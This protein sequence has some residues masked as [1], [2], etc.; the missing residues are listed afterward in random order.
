MSPDLYDLVTKFPVNCRVIDWVE[1][2]FDVMSSLASPPHS[3]QAV[4]SN[5]LFGKKYGISKKIG[6]HVFGTLLLIAAAVSIA[7]QQRAG[8]DSPPAY[9][10]FEIENCPLEGSGAV[11]HNGLLGI[12]PG[13]TCIKGIHHA[14]GTNLEHFD[15]TACTLECSN[16]KLRADDA[17]DLDKFRHGCYEDFVGRV[18]WRSAGGLDPLQQAALRQLYDQLIALMN[19]R[20]TKQYEQLGGNDKRGE[21]KKSITEFVLAQMTPYALECARKNGVAIPFE[22]FRYPNNFHDVSTTA[23]GMGTGSDETGLYVNVDEDMFFRKSGTTFIATPDILAAAFMHEAVHW[24]QPEH[25][26][27]PSGPPFELGGKQLPPGV[28]AHELNDLMAYDRCSASTFYKIVLRRDDFNDLVEAG[29]TI[30]KQRFALIWFHLDDAEKIA[31][32]KWAWGQSDDFMRRMMM[33]Y[34]YDDSGTWGLLCSENH[35]TGPCGMVG[36]NR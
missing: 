21:L 18:L 25:G 2:M 7:A 34:P 8:F 26:L 4:L 24:G 12:S 35:G 23:E 19:A 10:K 36:S 6:R 27:G 32:A 11:C 15:F 9:L 22:K 3:N 13:K 17:C 29:R 31:V 33:F 30:S 20:G 5:E 1:K 14:D 28:A 16:P